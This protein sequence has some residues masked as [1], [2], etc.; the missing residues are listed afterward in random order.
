MEQKNKPYIPENIKQYIKTAERYG[1]YSKLKEQYKI[2]EEEEKD[3][4]NS[5]LLLLSNK[6]FQEEYDSS[7]DRYI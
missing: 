1:A 2:I 4:P 3:D 6:T 5:N 7:V